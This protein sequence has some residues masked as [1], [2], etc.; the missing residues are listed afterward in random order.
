M[1]Q[2]ATFWVLVSAVQ[3]RK[4]RNEIPFIRI[5]LK[6]PYLCKDK[7]HDQFLVCVRNVAS[8]LH[9]P[10]KSHFLPFKLNHDSQKTQKLCLIK[11]YLKHKIQVL[12]LKQQLFAVY[13]LSLKATYAGCV[14]INK[15]LRLKRYLKH[16]IQVLYLK[17]QLFVICRIPVK[18]KSDI[19]WL[20][21]YK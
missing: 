8:F 1:K 4:K 19:C 2:K 3:K 11:P 5:E 7:R 16:K 9:F 17:Q 6:T 12:Y 15:K 10:T 13:P 20:R 18:S 14:P 21:S